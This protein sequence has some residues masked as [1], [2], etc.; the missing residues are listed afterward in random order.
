MMNKRA[1]L[2]LLAPLALAACQKPQ[3][4]PADSQSSAVTAQSDAGSAMEA[5]ASAP[6]GR[7]VLPVIAGHPG[8]AYIAWR[9]TGTAPVTITGLEITGASKAEMHE[10]KGGAML[11]Q[12]KLALAPGEEANFAPGGRHVMVYGLPAGAKAGDKLP[13]TLLLSDGSKLAGTL[14][15]EEAGGGADSTMGGMK[16]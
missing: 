9:N 7:L 14:T 4:P 1:A 3:T 8:A 16:M 12:P 2:I 11:P 5:Q 10:T 6:G 13:Y 15:V